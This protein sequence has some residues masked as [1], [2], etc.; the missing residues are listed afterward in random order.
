M[1]PIRVRPASNSKT[2]DLAP[3]PRWSLPLMILAAVII[4]AAL[5]WW[6]AN[7][8][9][10]AGAPAKVEHRDVGPFHA[11]QVGGI[12]QVRLEQ[13][14]GESIDVEAT[15]DARVKSEVVDGH[16]VIH[17]EDRTPW[18]SHLFL[19]RRTPPAQITVRFRSIDAIGISGGVAIEAASLAVPALNINASGGT[20]LS[21]GDLRA[22]TLHVRGSGALRAKLAGRVGTENVSISGAGSYAAERLIAQNATVSVSGVGNVVVHA[23]RTLNADISGAGVIEYVGNPD[24]TQHVTGIGRVE[25]RETRK[26]A[27]TVEAA[28]TGSPA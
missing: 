25:R 3:M 13:G 16:L 9:I 18:F 4:A 8:T 24:V 21:V 26:P 6:T 27:M 1:N 2:F 7:R 23:E 5:A 20:S 12:A 22:D 10:G 15:R 19:R 28:S 14:D 11:L 17:A